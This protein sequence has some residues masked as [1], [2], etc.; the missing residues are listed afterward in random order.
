MNHL[1]VF[2]QSI[3]IYGMLTMPGTMIGTG[4]TTIKIMQ[5]KE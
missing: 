1:T 4:A 3:N 5:L 2:F